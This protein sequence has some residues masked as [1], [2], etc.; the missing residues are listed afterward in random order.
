MLTTRVKYG[1]RILKQQSYHPRGIENLPRTSRA[2][3]RFLPT[4]HYEASNTNVRRETGTPKLAGRASDA[5]HVG[6]GILVVDEFV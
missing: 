6:A 5:E 4:P 2:S 3:A 1:T